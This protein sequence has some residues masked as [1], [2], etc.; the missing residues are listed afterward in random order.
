MNHVYIIPYRYTY[1]LWRFV[2][3]YIYIYVQYLCIHHGF[4]N[5]HNIFHYDFNY[6][7]QFSETDCDFHEI[8]HLMINL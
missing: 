8:P 7:H 4:I 6:V 2:Y 5:V 1:N 3:M